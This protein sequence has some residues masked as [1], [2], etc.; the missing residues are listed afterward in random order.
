MVAV[1]D[2]QGRQLAEKRPG[3][4]PIGNCD[5]VAAI[6]E[7]IERA[8]VQANGCP[9]DVG[10]VEPVEPENVADA[11]Q[12]QNSAGWP[13]QHGANIDY[14]GACPAGINRKTDC[15][16]AIVNRDKSAVG[17][18]FDK[19]ETRNRA[20]VVIPDMTRDVVE[21]IGDRHGTTA[22]PV[23]PVADSRAAADARFLMPPA[24]F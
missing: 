24:F 22:V 6:G 9:G 23:S 15:L 3:F 13:D 7:P 19:T 16:F 20:R 12:C 8:A 18:W 21:K 17:Q 10:V 2:N 4:P 11:A 1:I 5:P 14:V